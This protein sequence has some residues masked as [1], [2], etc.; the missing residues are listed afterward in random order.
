MAEHVADGDP[1]RRHR[2]PQLEVGDVPADGLVPVEEAVVDEGTDGGGREGLG[3]RGQSHRRVGGDGQVF[4]HVAPPE[5]LLE[6]NLSP[7][8][9]RHGRTGDLVAF[10]L[11]SQPFAHPSRLGK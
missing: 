5:A 8:H 1:F 3:R 6:H 9:H 7:G 11:R 10:D 2:V 4:F